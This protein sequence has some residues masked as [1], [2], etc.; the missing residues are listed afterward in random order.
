M[1]S[2]I[3]NARWLE[4]FY[5]H[6]TYLWYEP[7]FWFLRAILIFC[8]VAK[9]IAK[10]QTRG[11]ELVYDK[12]NPLF[13]EFVEKSNIKKLRFEP[14]FL[15]LS[16]FFQ[17]FFYLIAETLAKTFAA[18]ENDRELIKAKDGGT[19]G[20]EWTPDLKTR[21]GKPPQYPTKK[22][23][24]ILLFMPGLGG[25][26]YN[27]YSMALLWVARKNGFKCATVLFRGSDGIPITSPHLSHSCCW[28]DAQ[29]ATEYVYN[30][31]CVDPKTGEKNRRFYVYGVSLGANILGL[32]LK[33]DA[34]GVKKM[35][36]GA[37]LYCC[38]WGVRDGYKFFYENMG[39]MYSWAIGMILSEKIRCGQ[40]PKMKDLFSPEDYEYY[41]NFF[42][43]NWDGLRGIDKHV[44]CKMF[45]YT[46]VH[47]Y[48]DKATVLG[49]LNN[50]SVP[51]FAFGSID[52]QVCTDKETPRKEIQQAGS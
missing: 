43:N 44:Y 51:T 33:K 17:S 10:W 21:E 35:V 1:S 52:D 48:Y 37:L 47:D 41:L 32:Y 11:L 20:I 8:L 49:G 3:L 26:A 39:G 12:S 25:G 46:D 23:A 22:E 6:L 2:E 27:L 40:L 15:G 9:I 38:P 16:P 5:D 30:K 28:E 45:G 14:Y 4:L 13:Q 36:D 42:N 34:K 7:R 29:V 31:Y 19:L 24:P 18:E 50:V